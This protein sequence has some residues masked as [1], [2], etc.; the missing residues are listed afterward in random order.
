M[1]RCET[2]RWWELWRHPARQYPYDWGTCRRLVPIQN[3]NQCPETASDAGVYDA[4]TD[5]NKFLSGADF[6][7]TLW[8]G[9]ACD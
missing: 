5:E 2:C 8:E 9:K 4:Y 7:C 6:G 3:E 1:E